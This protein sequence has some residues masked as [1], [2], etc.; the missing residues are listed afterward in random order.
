MVSAF[1]A[2][3]VGLDFDSIGRILP[4]PCKPALCPG[5]NEGGKVGSDSP[6]AE[7]LRSAEGAEKF[8]QC[9]KYFLQQQICF[10]KALGLNIGAP[11]LF[12]APSAI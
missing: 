5:R 11:N 8:Q 7:S 9:C 2:I 1:A 12:L 3:L 10:R 4:R 6:S